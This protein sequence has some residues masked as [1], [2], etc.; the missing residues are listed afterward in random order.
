MNGAALPRTAVVPAG[1]FLMGND[2]GRPDERPAH[3][4]WLDAFAMELVPVSNADYARF[5]EATGHEPSGEWGSPRFSLPDQPVVGVS[6]FDACAYCS[7]LSEISGRHVRLPTE[8]EREK[9]ARGGLEGKRYPWGDDPPPSGG[10]F[11]VGTQGMDCPQ[12]VGQQGPNGFGLYDMAYNVH[13]WCADWYMADYY[14]VSP[15]R[16]PRGPECGIR[17]SSRGGAWRHHLKTTPCSARSSIPPA[18]RYADY[19]FRWVMDADAQ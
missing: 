8:A 13:E 2:A 15:L 5:L 17:R 9:A 1:A 7:W 14:A 4:V 6:W 3:L 16:N 12:A 11:A 10:V 19:G 18:N